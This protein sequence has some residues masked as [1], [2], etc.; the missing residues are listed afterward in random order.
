[1]VPANGKAGVRSTG[2]THG[3]FTT[4]AGG[5][6]GVRAGRIHGWAFDSAR[7]TARLVVEAVSLSGARVQVIA[8]RYRADVHKSGWGDGYSGFAIPL[9]GLGD[10]AGVRVFC[11]C[12]KIELPGPASL[13]KRG[14]PIRVQRRSYT[15]HLDE[16]QP[17]APLTG[18][19]V[20]WDCPDRRRVLLLQSKTGHAVRQRATQFRD[21][22]RNPR[23]DGY[24]GFSLPAPP[25][26]GATITDLANGVS[27]RVS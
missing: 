6:D 24:L 12:P 25:G 20:D 11:C 22:I 23:S 8:D 10:D 27:I 5:Y 16:R 15:L 3:A 18:W 21:D 7:P 13:P 9:G 19:A 17:G 26:R 14:R 2:S 1:M 4:V